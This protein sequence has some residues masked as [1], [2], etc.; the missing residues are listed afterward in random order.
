MTINTE[1]KG[2]MISSTRSVSDT[3]CTKEEKYILRCHTPCDILLRNE[4]VIVETLYKLPSRSMPSDVLIRNLF[5]VQQSPN[6][7]NEIP[8]ECMHTDFYNSKYI[9]L[10]FSFDGST[11]K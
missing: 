7:L 10:K 11:T 4:E 6:P 9:L 1:H 2:K 8:D 3:G 5:L